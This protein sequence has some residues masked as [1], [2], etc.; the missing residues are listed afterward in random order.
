MRD[1]RLW[2]V[3]KGFAWKVS[4][5]GM[6]NMISVSDLARLVRDV[7]VLVDAVHH[8]VVV[9]VDCDASPLVEVKIIGV[10]LKRNVQKT[11]GFGF[12]ARTISFMVLFSFS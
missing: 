1:G 6:T 2:F 8:L 7:K 5:E 10:T 4:V 3:P 12:I 11:P 9:N